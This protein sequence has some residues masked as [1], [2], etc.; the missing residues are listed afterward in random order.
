MKKHATVK[1]GEYTIPLIGI[2]ESST[3]QK[4]FG[5]GKSF[6]LSD[7]KLDKKGNPYCPECLPKS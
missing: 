2:P 1:I 3:Q 6:H 4:C 5:C 7:I